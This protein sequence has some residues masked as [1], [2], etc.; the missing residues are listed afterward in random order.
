MEDLFL[1]A[2]SDGS[3]NIVSKYIRKGFNVNV[4]DGRGETGLIKAS[5]SGEYSIIKMLLDAGANINLTDASGRNAL[6]YAVQGNHE[7]VSKLL[8]VNK[9]DPKQ[10]TRITNSSAKDYTIKGVCDFENKFLEPNYLQ[11]LIAIKS[12]ENQCK[13]AELD[14]PNNREDRI[15]NM[16]MRYEDMILSDLE[17]DGDDKTGGEVFKKEKKKKKKGKKSAKGKKKSGG[18][19]KK[20]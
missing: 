18:K 3:T 20:K 10:L 15:Y 2:C 17:S 19:K 11:Q 9:I 16:I 14:E 5:L 7:K 1:Q 4:R 6:H 13:L 8:C 12:A